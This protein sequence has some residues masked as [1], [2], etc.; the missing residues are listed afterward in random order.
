MS[1]VWEHWHTM[2]FQRLQVCFPSR[3]AGEVCTP[4][5]PPLPSL[6]AGAPRVRWGGPAVTLADLEREARKGGVTVFSS[7]LN[8]T[9][10]QYC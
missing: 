10:V 4:S 8:N 7:P 6:A 9:K 3:E 1:Q 2:Y 5:L